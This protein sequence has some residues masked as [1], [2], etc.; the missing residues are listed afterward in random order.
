MK[1]LWVGCLLFFLGTSALG[2]SAIGR[3]RCAIRVDV[4]YASG[5]HAPARLQVSLINRFNGSPYA[6]G[7]T[8]SSGIA[9][10]ADVAPGAYYVVVSG[11]EIEA[12][13]SGNF[14]V[15]GWSTFLSQSVFVKQSKKAASA[16]VPNQPTI[17]AKELAVP[18]TAAKEY[19]LGNDAMANKKWMKAIDHFT[20][21]IGIFPQFY[22]AYNNM[23]GC[24]AELGQPEQQRSALEKAISLNNGCITCLLNL[25]YLDMREG[26][27]ADASVLAD[28]A[29]TL[30]PDSVE[31][32][33]RRAEIDFAQGRYDSAIAA[34]RKA[35]TLPHRSF[36]VVHYTAASAFEREGKN[37]EAVAELRLFLQ[38]S[39]DGPGAEMARKAIATLQNRAQ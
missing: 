37:A 3:D 22:S 8:N 24:Y 28:K 30:D 2:Q 20:R 13:K 5:G 14:D 38:E 12:S 34:A 33:A 32:L 26:N 21:A 6:V 11:A 25:S 7:V 19:D 1:L 39:P 31:G 18:A 29:L 36:P 4:F 17:S 23:A 15:T 9:E 16:L 10:F 35:H 27:Y